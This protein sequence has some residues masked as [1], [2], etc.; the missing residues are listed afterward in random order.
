MCLEEGRSKPVERSAN[1]LMLIDEQQ[2]MVVYI[3]L[4]S[5][6][7]RVLESVAL[8]PLL[9]KKGGIKVRSTVKIVGGGA[10][11]GGGGGGQLCNL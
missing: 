1:N 7:G 9:P 5:L 3:V 6:P 2:K 8:I 11:G 10:K 4:G